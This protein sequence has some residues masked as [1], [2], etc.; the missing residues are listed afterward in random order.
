MRKADKTAQEIEP[1]QQLK[2]YIE[3]VKQQGGDTGK[4]TYASFK[5][6]NGLPYTGN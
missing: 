1:P 6:K 2:E 4:L 3:Y 5:T